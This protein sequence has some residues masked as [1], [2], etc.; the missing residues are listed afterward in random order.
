MNLFRLNPHH[1]HLLE[2]GVPVDPQNP[3]RTDLVPA[4]PLQYQLDQRFLNLFQYRPVEIGRLVPPM[5]FQKVV[6]LSPEDLLQGEIVELG[7]AGGHPF[8]LDLRD[9][10]SSR[11]SYDRP[12][13]HL[14]QLRH[15]LP[16]VVLQ[17]LP[18]APGELLLLQAQLVAILFD[19]KMREEG[20][21]VAGYPHLPVLEAVAPQDIRRNVFPDAPLFAMTDGK[22]RE[23]GKNYA[24]TLQGRTQHFREREPE[25]CGWSGVGGRI[26]SGT[27]NRA[28]QPFRNKRCRAPFVN[29]W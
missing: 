21:L 5:P 20:N 17:R 19:K 9:L 8:E 18:H 1:L 11:I 6:E 27:L 10:R 12:F 23:N 25:Y 16:R 2:E 3:C 15:I 24:T 14:F 4:G 13:D 7:P 29:S 26:G 22:L 28:C